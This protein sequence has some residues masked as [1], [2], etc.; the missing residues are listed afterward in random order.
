MQAVE[1]LHTLSGMPYWLS[2]CALTAVVKALTLPISVETLRNQAKMLAASG[3][4][5]ELKKRMNA[6]LANIQANPALQMKYQEEMQA[7]QQRH[8]ISMGRMLLL[9]FMQMPIGITMFFGMKAMPEYYP[10]MAKGGALW[11]TDLG[12]V[13]ST[14]I[15]PVMVAVPLIINME[16]FQGEQMKKNPQMQAIMRGLT[17]AIIP[18]GTIQPQAV[19]C[20]WLA[21]NTIT[22]A[23][24]RYGLL[25]L[26]SKPI[27][28]L[29]GLLSCLV[30]IRFLSFLT[31]RLSHSDH[32]L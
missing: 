10:E 6:D 26:I 21:T 8:G 13:D 16:Y 22:V 19:L 17:L 1:S 4:M 25:S 20:Y 12:T 31:T 9:P 11:F 28:L 14:F 3:P 5:E 30:Q 23:S 24:V 29:L 27:P 2:I 18:I 15:L 32:K 7:I